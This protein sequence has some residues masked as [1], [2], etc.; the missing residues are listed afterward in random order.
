MERALNRTLQQPAQALR[1]LETERL[2][3]LQLALWPKAMRGD[4]AAVKAILRLMERRARLLGLD[5]SDGL[6]ERAQRLDEL[7]AALVVQAVTGILADLQLSP[8]QQALV[9]TVVPARLRAIA[10]VPDDG[11][12][13]GEVVEDAQAE[14]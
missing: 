11:T 5:H 10:D 4:V 6:A 3:R 2:D 12:I 9:A 14:G 13:E 8:E 1:D 7:R